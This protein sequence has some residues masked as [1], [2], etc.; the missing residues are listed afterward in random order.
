MLVPVQLPKGSLPHFCPSHQPPP[1][2]CSSAALTR[3]FSNSH[4]EAISVVSAGFATR[5]SLFLCDAT[6]VYSQMNNEN[7][8]SATE[9]LS[10][11]QLSL[12]SNSHD[13]SQSGNHLLHISRSHSGARND[14]RSAT[15]Q[16]PATAHHSVCNCDSEPITLIQQLFTSLSCI[17]SYYKSQSV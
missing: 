16:L 10:L 4:L 8:Y 12:C 14:P 7:S 2:R 15:L 5:N 3:H 17:Q 9:Q 13:T 11:S 1:L 6:T